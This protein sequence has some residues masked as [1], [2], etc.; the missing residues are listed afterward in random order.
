MRRAAATLALDCAVPDATADIPPV[1]SVDASEIRSLLNK[2]VEEVNRLAAAIAAHAQL[3]ELEQ[4]CSDAQAGIVVRNALVQQR[5][6]KL[7][8]LSNEAV[9]KLYRYA[10]KIRK[11]AP[12]YWLCGNA[13]CTLCPYETQTRDPFY[14]RKRCYAYYALLWNTLKSQYAAYEDRTLK[15]AATRRPCITPK[16]LRLR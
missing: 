10:Q 5:R 6:K 1:S 15:P 16:S 14:Q 13:T 9:D 12:A 3:R 2:L 8:V 7:P 4:Q 11:I